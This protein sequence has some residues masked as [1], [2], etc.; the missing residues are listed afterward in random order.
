MI[1]KPPSNQNKTPDV[2]I[3]DFLRYFEDVRF[4]FMKVNGDWFPAQS[5]DIHGRHPGE[6]VLAGNVAFIG[7]VIPRG[8]S[9]IKEVVARIIPTTSGTIDYTFTA[10]FGGKNEDESTGTSTITADGLAV[11]DD[12]VTEI[13]IT[14]LFS[15]AKVDDQFGIEFSLDAVST[16][17][18]VFLLGINFKYR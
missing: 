8:I 4:E 9:E 17:A 10:N 6:Q 2:W 16:T 3:Q 11:V 13:D 15:T 12:R 18:N 7:M 5:N 14:A 1:S